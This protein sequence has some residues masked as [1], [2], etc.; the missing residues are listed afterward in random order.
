MLSNGRARVRFS[1]L[2]SM[3]TAVMAA[4]RCRNGA[5][6]MAMAMLVASLKKGSGSAPGALEASHSVQ[7]LAL[8]T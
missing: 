2:A 3:T 1:R 8:S 7:L 6:A 5:A 4:C